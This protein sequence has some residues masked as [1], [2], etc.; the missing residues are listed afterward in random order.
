MW[1]ANIAVG[2]RLRMP[3]IDR[4][5]AVITWD[6]TRQEDRN[7]HTN[8]HADDHEGNAERQRGDKHE[9]RQTEIHGG[10]RFLKLCA[11]CSV[12]DTLLP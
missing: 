9:F 1:I 12:G 6:G 3:A 11:S 8:E 10:T 7:E 5:L 2:Q 4:R